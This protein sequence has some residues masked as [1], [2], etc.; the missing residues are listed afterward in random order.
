MP[1]TVSTHIPMSHLAGCHALD[2]RCDTHP[3][4]GQC[5]CRD[6]YPGALLVL[7]IPGK[8]KGAARPRFVRLGNGHVRTHMPSAHVEA[9]TSAMLLLQ[10]V[11]GR[12]PLNHP[13]GLTI[14]VVLARPKSLCRKVDPPGRIR[15]T[16]KPDADNAAK[17]YMDALTKAGV[18]IDDTR[19]AELVV[20]KWYTAVGEQP[21]VELVVRGL[22]P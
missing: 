8:P 9:E 2:A 17:L 4:A 13:V 11:W 21:G 16:S 5:T 12:D 14:D 3:M 1:I 20:R 10:S 15:C 6:P 22:A 18:L 7:R 19:V